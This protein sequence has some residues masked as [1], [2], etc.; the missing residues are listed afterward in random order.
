MIHGI[1]VLPQAM[2]DHEER[3]VKCGVTRP[4]IWFS[5]GK[6]PD[7]VVKKGFRVVYVSRPG[8]DKAWAAMTNDVT[9]EML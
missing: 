2:L 9:R 1:Q 5:T 6:V 4:D 7:L 8:E 3:L